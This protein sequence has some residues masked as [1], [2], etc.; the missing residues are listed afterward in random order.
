VLIMKKII[1]ILLIVL[2]IV[3]LVGCG[4]VPSGT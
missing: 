4:T 2:A 3:T 1:L